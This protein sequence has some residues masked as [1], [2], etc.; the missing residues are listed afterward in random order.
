L[1]TNRNRLEVPAID[2]EGGTNNQPAEPRS[3]RNRDLGRWLA[4]PLLVTVVAALL[5]S[6]LL[7]QVTRKWQDHQQALEIQTSLV[8]QM[9]ESVSSTVATGRFIASG[10][11]GGD[12]G[13]RTWNDGYRDWVTESASIG[14]K[15]QAYFGRELGAEWQSFGYVVTDFFLLSARP[16]S[17]RGEQIDE[18][19]A[20]QS[21]PKDLLDR[22][23][24]AALGRSPTDSSFQT[25]YADL[26]RGLLARSDELVSR[27]LDSDLSGF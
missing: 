5:G 19:R 16:T 11:V 4:N 1:A 9:S 23:E 25:A 14:A 2:S 21:M 20:Y 27:V 17:A 24:W 10:L 13:Q 18:I 22:R 15:L 6:W 12:V 26:A 8:S 3:S 7:P